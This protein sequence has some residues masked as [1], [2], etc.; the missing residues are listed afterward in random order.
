MSA[1]LTVPDAIAFLVGPRCGTLAK[2]G[3]LTGL[4]TGGQADPAA[5]AFS[6][7]R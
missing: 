3:R 1:I 5:V 2:S 6:A 7:F 4:Q